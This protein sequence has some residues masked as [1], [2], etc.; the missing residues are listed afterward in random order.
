MD[1]AHGGAEASAMGFN[2]IHVDS[3]IWSIGLGIVFC[4]LF[5]SGREKRPSPAFPSGWVNALRDDRR[6]SSTTP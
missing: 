4:W 5:R 1:L 3:M 2:A 6:V